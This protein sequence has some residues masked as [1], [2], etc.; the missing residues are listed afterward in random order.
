MI[1]IIVLVSH[2]Q[3]SDSFIQT[4]CAKF[5][6]LYPTLCDPVDYSPP[7]SSVHGIFSARILEW[8]SMSFSRGQNP[9]SCTEGGFFTT[10]TIWEAQMYGY[11]LYIFRLLSII[12]YN[13][14]LDI[15]PYCCCLVAKSCLTLLTPWTAACQT[16]LSFTISWSLCKL[17]S[18]ESVMLTIA[19]FFVKVKIIWL[20]TCQSIV[21]S[22]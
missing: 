3:Q 20:Q 18:I 2:L 14:M 22:L 9:V 21:I 5:L 12:G 8:V 19:V 11:L 1:H 15:D 13:K 16:S 6:Q 7:A 17:M 4:H 10:S